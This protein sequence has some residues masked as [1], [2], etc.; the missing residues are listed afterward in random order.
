M[1]IVSLETS[2]EKYFILADKIISLRQ[3]PI[4]GLLPASTAI[5]SM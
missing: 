2:L 5:N 1:D 3:G 4:I